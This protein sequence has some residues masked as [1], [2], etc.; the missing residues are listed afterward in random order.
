MNIRSMLRVGAIG[1]TALISTAAVAGMGDDGSGHRRGGWNG[2]HRFAAPGYGGG[3][4]RGGGYRGAGYAY[5]YRQVVRGGGY[6]FG[7]G[8]RYGGC[9]GGFHLFGGC[10]GGAY[11]PPVAAYLPPSPPPLEPVEP[12][13][14]EPVVEPDP[15]PVY[16]PPLVRSVAY[17]TYPLPTTSSVIYNRPLLYPGWPARAGYGYYGTG[18][19]CFCH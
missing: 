8:Y 3:Y 2:G 15:A 4:H 10:G 12:P 14:P 18:S 16:A 11:V 7:G 19:D 9:G 5:G 1:A 17:P 13:G 6:S